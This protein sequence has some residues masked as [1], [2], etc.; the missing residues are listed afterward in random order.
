MQLLLTL[1]ELLIVHIQMVQICVHICMHTFHIQRVYP[2]T[3]DTTNIE[4][5]ELFASVFYYHDYCFQ[6]HSDINNDPK[7]NGFVIWFTRHARIVTYT[8]TVFALIDT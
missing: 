6:Y 8:R 4:V 7:K 3:P 5:I 1:L 2:H